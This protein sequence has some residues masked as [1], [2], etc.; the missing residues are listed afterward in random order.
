MDS[1]F[2]AQEALVE[3]IAFEP[4]L[5]FQLQLGT[6]R[7]LEIT[8]RHRAPLYVAGSAGAGLQWD[9]DGAAHSSVTLDAGDVVW[10]PRGGRHRIFTNPHAP[11][12]RLET[13]YRA[14]A[15]ERHGKTWNLTLGP[16]PRDT[17]HTWSGS[18]YWAWRLAAHPLVAALPPV[19]VLRHSD[20]MDW[21]PSM[22]QL[23]QW[24]ADL[25]GGKGLGL[26]QAMNALMQH[27]VLAWLRQPGQVATPCAPP[28]PPLPL[29]DG[30][31]GPALHAMHTQPATGWTLP[32]LAALCHMSRTSFIQRFQS[33]LGQPP[34]RHLAQWRLYLASRL[35]RHEGATWQQAA[36]AVGYSS[37]AV[38]ARAFKWAVLRAQDPAPADA[39]RPTPESP[40]T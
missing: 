38:L 16:A 12:Q 7:C 39:P 22:A 10:L 35:L 1:P 3:A 36:D 15:A 17:H 30:R 2:P 6:G 26:T 33:R 40:V 11:V 24:M 28:H 14:H 34:M 9:G 13:L 31:L 20:A 29:R 19:L 8:N 37:G 32:A 23:V 5:H 4:L 18:F 27:L 25:R 21:L